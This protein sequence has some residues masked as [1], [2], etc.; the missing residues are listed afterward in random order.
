MAVDPRRYFIPH[1]FYLSRSSIYFPTRHSLQVY[2]LHTT[3]LHAT[4][5]ATMD[6]CPNFFN[7]VTWGCFRPAASKESTPLPSIHGSLRS[8]AGNILP[9]KS[10]AST[11][12]SIMEVNFGSEG[13]SEYFTAPQSSATSRSYHTARTSPW[14]GSTTGSVCGS[15]GMKSISTESMYRGWGIERCSMI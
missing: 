14:M 8:G 4:F 5:T 13:R 1:T 10:H 11:R 3:P 12:K 15:T 9:P 6:I 7:F 2:I